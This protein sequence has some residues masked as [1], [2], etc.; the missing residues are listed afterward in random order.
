MQQQPYRAREIVRE[1]FDKL[2]NYDAH[3]DMYY[4]ARRMRKLLNELPEDK[5]S[6]ILDFGGGSGLFSYELKKS[7]Y[8]NLYLMDLSEVQV[9]QAKEKG[10]VHAYQGDEHALL[11]KFKK[12]SFDFVLMADVIEHVEDPVGVLEKVSSVLKPSGKLLLT[13]PNPLWVPALNLFGNIGLKL[14]GKDNKIYLKKLV[15]KLNNGHN[16][17]QLV[18]HEGHMLVSKLP[19]PALHF[20][21][22]VEK[23]VPQGVKRTV[24]LLN[25]AV[26]VKNE[27]KP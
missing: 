8:K 15:Q 26:F 18:S 21:E 5:S 14:K 2:D 4:F 6:K 9:R 25:T 11:R 17:L 24:C 23:Y 27:V 13:Y 1:D 10:L 19:R 22:K 7:G 12:D 3:R 16:S 20:F